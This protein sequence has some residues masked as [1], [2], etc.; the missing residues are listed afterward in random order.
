M[1]EKGEGND[2]VSLC[3]LIGKKLVNE[4]KYDERM[5]IIENKRK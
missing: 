1:R 5:R 2:A 4:N 3:R